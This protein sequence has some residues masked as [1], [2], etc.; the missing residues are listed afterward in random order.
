M[1]L[2]KALIIPVVGLLMVG[3]ANY[4][5]AAGVY[6]GLHGA[7]GLCWLVN[8]AAFRDF[9]WETRVTVAGGAF[10][11]VLL[12][13]YRVAPF[14]LVS[15]ALAPERQPPPNWLLGVRMGLFTLGVTTWVR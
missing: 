5:T 9:R 15:G 14:L 13:T 7:Y 2:H 8:H 1:D 6:L 11:F 4:S 3:F 10:T 12:G